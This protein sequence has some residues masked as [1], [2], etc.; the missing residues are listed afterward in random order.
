[1]NTGGFEFGENI[2]L[3]NQEFQD[4]WFVEPLFSKRHSQII[5]PPVAKE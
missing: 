1:M 2:P 3:G 5:S 4:V